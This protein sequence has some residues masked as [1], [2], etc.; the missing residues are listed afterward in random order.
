[1]IRRYTTPKMVALTDRDT[2]MFIYLQILAA[3]A[4]A[5]GHPEAAAAIATVHPDVETWDEYETR[6]RHETAAFVFWL[7]D[8][9]PAHR[10]HVYVGMTSSD[11]QDTAE[12]ALWNVIWTSTL[13]PQIVALSLRWENTLG[14]GTRAGRTH[15][16]DTELPVSIAAIYRRSARNLSELVNVIDRTRLR[17]NLSGPVGTYS[18]FLT[19]AQATDAATELGLELDLHST[20]TADRHRMAALAMLLVQVIGA[21]EQVATYQRLSTISGV[22]QYVEQ[23]VNLQQV[24]SSSMPH[25]RNP[26]SSERICGLARVAR[27]NLSALLETC[28]TQ[29]WERDL[30]NSSVERVA[31]RDLVALAD[32][33]TSMALQIDVGTD[34]WNS[35]NVNELESSYY[36][37]N[38]ALLDGDDP[39]SA[40]Q[41]L[42]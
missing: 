23:H 5:Q 7:R 35:T 33:L 30:T 40:Y 42:K 34:T 2:L 38:Q 20:Q 17:A 39:T 11:L 32:Y 31:W 4:R 18:T 27:S 14:I 6:H 1:M 16:R 3:V 21:I 8:Q 15:G 41:G 12:A 26:I 10:Q 22:D 13:R 25:K 24:G 9:I 19:F 36:R 29:W 37:Y 28:Y